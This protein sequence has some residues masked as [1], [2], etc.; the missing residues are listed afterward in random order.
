MK[1]RGNVTRA[2][3]GPAIEMKSRAASASESRSCFSILFT[4]SGLRHLLPKAEKGL[5][6][7][8]HFVACAEAGAVEVAVA[9]GGAGVG[10][11]AAL[12]PPLLI[13]MLRARFH[14]SMNRFPA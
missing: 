13:T 1:F 14:A 11:G 10:A 4:S 7:R 8:R 9:P 3:P 2:V 5:F 6:A 12:W